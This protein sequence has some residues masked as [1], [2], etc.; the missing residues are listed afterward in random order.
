MGKIRKR[1]NIEDK[2][3]ILRRMVKD[4]INYRRNIEKC[5]FNERKNENINY[6]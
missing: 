1:R 4:Y 5:R 6:Y 3:I 2:E